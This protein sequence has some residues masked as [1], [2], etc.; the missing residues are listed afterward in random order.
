[1]SSASGPATRP[2]C[3]SSTLTS[4]VISG[5]TR[6]SASR[7]PGSFTA[8]LGD[9]VRAGIDMEQLTGSRTL[10]EVIEVLERGLHGGGERGGGSGPF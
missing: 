1:M 5:S 2:T 3:S 6:S 4:R 10:R 8:D 9:E 7:S